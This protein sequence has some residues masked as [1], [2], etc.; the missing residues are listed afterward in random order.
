MTTDEQRDRDAFEIVKALILA[1]TG[2]RYPTIFN[3]AEFAEQ[4]YKVV[5]ALRAAK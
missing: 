5:D 1:Q 4:A 3:E 2:K